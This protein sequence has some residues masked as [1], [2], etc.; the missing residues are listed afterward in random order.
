M[1]FPWLFFLDGAAS[2]S[3]LLDQLSDPWVL[4]IFPPRLLNLTSGVD[5]QLFV[6]VW[7]DITMGHHPLSASS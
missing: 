6:V 5:P 1:I 2:V 7:E 4:V 3:P